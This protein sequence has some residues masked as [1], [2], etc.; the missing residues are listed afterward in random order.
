MTFE[1]QTY[2]LCDGWVN[3]W[4]DDDVL[5]TFDTYEAAQAELDDHLADLAHAVENGHMDDYSADD[6][7]IVRVTA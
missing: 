7:R 1:I 4:T 2:T 6:Y 5:V 3:T